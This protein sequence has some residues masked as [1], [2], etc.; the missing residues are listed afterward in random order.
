[1]FCVMYMAGGPILDPILNP[2]I[3]LRT[4]FEDVFMDT[5]KET[6][7]LPEIHPLGEHFQ[8]EILVPQ[9]RAQLQ[10]KHGMNKDLTV[11]ARQ[12]KEDATKEADKFPQG[13]ITHHHTK[14]GIKNI[15]IYKRN[16]KF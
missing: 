10:E 9:R 13:G 15:V 6:Q 5:K 14:E 2:K 1:M 16:C 8:E 4:E 11:H 12:L 7:F 3:G